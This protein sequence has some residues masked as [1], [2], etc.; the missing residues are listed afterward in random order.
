V[1]EK[2]LLVMVCWAAAKL[3]TG[4]KLEPEASD[5]TSSVGGEEDPPLLARHLISTDTAAA[6]QDRTRR[7]RKTHI[8]RCS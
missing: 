6:A 7:N 1:E 3:S 5:A 2:K 4:W 8:C